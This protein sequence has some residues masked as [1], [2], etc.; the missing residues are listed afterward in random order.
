VHVIVADDEES[1]GELAMTAPPATTTKV[2]PAVSSIRDRMDSAP[3]PA[4]S[5]DLDSHGWAMIGKALTADECQMLAGLY[6]DDGRFRSHVV[7]ARHGFGRGEYRYFRYPL[8]EVVA[9]LRTAL[10]PRLA[11]FANRWHE[12]LGIEIRFPAEHPRHAR[13]TLGPR[14][15][16]V[17]DR[18]PARR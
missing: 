16:S 15:A 5:A 8:P 12:A 1:D 11:P 2:R 14:H 3:W 7:M 13:A 6:D 10:Y 9:S 17:R 4:L 18:G